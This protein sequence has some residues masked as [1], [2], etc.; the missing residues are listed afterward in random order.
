MTSTKLKAIAIFVEIAD[1]GSMAAAARSIGV[2]NSVITKNLN[3]LENWLGRKLIFRSTRN[4]RLTKDGLE[5]LE[6]CRHILKSVHNLEA[7]GCKDD[8]TIHGE[9]KI[10]APFYLGQYIFTPLIAE[11]HEAF[12]EVSINLSFSD[13]FKDMIDEGFDI[14]IR[15]SQMPDSSFISK[16]LRKASLRV[17][18]SNQY[19]EKHGAPSSP[20]DL[21]SHACLI[22]GDS[23]NRRRWQF[24]GKSNKQITVSINGKMRV[25]Y[26]GMI[27][28]ICKEGL[29]IAQ[30]PDFMVDEE[31]R[32]N[33]LV[34]LLPDYELDNFYIHLLYHKRSTTNRAI[35]S[36]IDFIYGNYR[37]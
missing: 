16:R 24:K 19:I 7:K 11:Y 22:E 2:V 15:A 10:T 36:V 29:G 21:R 14:A 35:K 37:N 3:E 18:A 20:K 33:E 9:V 34:R 31:I 5:Y 28:A 4:M 1:Q 8:E 30:L 32:N 17:V 23:D 27:K 6:E 13:D 25:N 12:P 26:G